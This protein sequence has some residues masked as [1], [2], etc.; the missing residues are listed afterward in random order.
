MSTRCTIHFH[1]ALEAEPSAIIYRH[2]DGYPDTE[3]GVPASLDRFFVAVQEQTPGDTRFADGAYLAAKFLVWQ[4][5][6]N[7]GDAMRPLAFL[8]V[9][10]LLHDPADIDYRYHVRCLPHFTD[11]I[12]T[13]DYE[14]VR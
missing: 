11:G 8:S 5:G 3:H 12:P 10:P 2:M 14:E 4:A 6:Q 1:D 9:A 13:V 7:G